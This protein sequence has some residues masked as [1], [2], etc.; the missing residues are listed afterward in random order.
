MNLYEQV[1]DQLTDKQREAVEYIDGPLLVIAGPGTGKTQL[2]SMRV[3]QILK[4]TDANSSNILCLTFTNKAATNMR[5]RLQNLIGSDSLQVNVKTFHSLS[6]EIM[7]EYPDYFWNGAKLATAPDAV[8]TDIIEGILSRLPLDNPLAVKFAGNYTS[9][10]RVQK[11]LKL[12]KEA[13]NSSESPEFLQQQD[14]TSIKKYFLQKS[15]R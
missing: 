11:A 9:I 15:A 6:A 14:N 10:S 1:F 3:A 12:T 13:G 2:L 8:Q 7:N 4:Q 5:N